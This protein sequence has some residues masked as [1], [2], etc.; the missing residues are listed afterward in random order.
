MQKKIWIV[1]SFAL[2]LTV[3]SWLAPRTMASHM[4]SPAASQPVGDQ[5][6]TVLNHTGVEINSL[7]VSP[8]QQ[9]DWGEDILG[10]DT[11][12]DGQSCHITFHPKEQAEQWDL[13]VT[14]S[15]GNG[16]IWY[17]LNLLQISKVALFYENGRGT[18]Q[19]E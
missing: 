17:N 3:G 10:Q 13:K 11:L 8:S 14:D 1:L 15:A 12:S 9:N 4:T 6:F 7:Y 16:L 2:L 5:D 18:A 19:V